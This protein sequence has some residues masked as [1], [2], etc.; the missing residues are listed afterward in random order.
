[1]ILSKNTPP[2]KILSL[3]FLLSLLYAVVRYHLFAGVSW[4]QL[5]LYVMNK[6]ASLTIVLLLLYTV[7]FS[8]V[9]TAEKKE[10]YTWA[11]ISLVLGHV[12][13]SFSLL[14]P[15]YFSK[16]FDAGKMHFKYELSMLFGIVA[17]IVF[18]GSLI[19]FLK[20]NVKLV[21]KFQKMILFLLAVHLFSMG[22]SSWIVP[23]KWY[24][25]MPPISLVAFTVLLIIIFV[26]KLK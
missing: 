23:F 8:R 6:V 9:L 24:G 19:A 26:K 22:F 13:I 11:I 25:A 12:L 10:W 2:V 18:I 1:M 20:G 16:F 5:P 3:F 14:S 21:S 4:D 15:E 7:W 17:F